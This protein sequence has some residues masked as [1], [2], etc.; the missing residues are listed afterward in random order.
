MKAA[1]PGS[2]EGYPGFDDLPDLLRDPGGVHALAR[3][4]IGNHMYQVGEER[5]LMG[6]LLGGIEWILRALPEV[7]L[8]LPQRHAAE[9]PQEHV[10]V[11]VVP[12]VLGGHILE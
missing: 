9:A 1:Y 3:Q 4:C 12:G 11:G 6:Q 10:V 5:F 2:P 7:V 8:V